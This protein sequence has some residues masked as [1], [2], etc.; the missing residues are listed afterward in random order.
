MFRAIYFGGK[1][2]HVSIGSAPGSG[3]RPVSTLIPGKILF[4]FNSLTNGV[5]SALLWY[6]VSSYK[7]APEI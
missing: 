5:P 2:Y 4:A 3:W 6:N 1:A 7:M